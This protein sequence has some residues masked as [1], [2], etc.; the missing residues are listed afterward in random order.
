MTSL[1][2]KISEA[3]TSQELDKIVTDNIK[4][5]QTMDMIYLC[6]CANLAKIRIYRNRKVAK[7]KIF[8]LN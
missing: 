7:L 1:I 8:E 5:V 4:K 3:K 2:I 6:K